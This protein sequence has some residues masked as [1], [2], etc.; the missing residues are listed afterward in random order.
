MSHYRLLLVAALLAIPS[1]HA[2]AQSGLSKPVFETLPHGIVH[3]RNTGP[4]QWVGTTGWKL[5]LERTVTADGDKAVFGTPISLAVDGSGR[6]IETDWKVDGLQVFEADGRFARVIGR[7]GQGP[8]EFKAPIGVDVHGD[9]IAAFA[10]NQRRISLW[11]TDGTLIAQWNIDLCC[12]T[13]PIIDPHGDILLEANAHIGSTNRRVAVRMR[14]GGRVVD[15]MLLP[16]EPPVPGWNVNGGIVSIPFVAYTQSTFDTHGRYISGN[17][18]H[19][20]LIVARHGSD[21][22]R[23]I[24]LPGRRIPVSTHVADSLFVPYT[25][26]APLNQVAK[27]GDIPTE[28]PYFGHLHADEH[29]NIWIERPAADGSVSAFDVTDQDGRFLGTVAAP[30]VPCGRNLFRNGRM[31]CIAG[32][33]DGDLVI[34]VYRVDK[35]AR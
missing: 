20:T 21:T 2:A 30:P 16:V 5:V 19:Y 11:H 35:G 7:T 31:Y 4:S 12:A 32:T 27:R 13:A 33:A 24:D 15:S 9:T 25:R 29:D 17:S 18:T 23:I 8:G 26:R 22:A 3:V 1:L 10:G 14:P 6:I 28:Q 34:Q